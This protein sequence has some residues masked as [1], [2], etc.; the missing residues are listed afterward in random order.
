MKVDNNGNSRLYLVKKNYEVIVKQGDVVDVGTPIFKGNII[1]RV[2]FIDMARILLLSL[3]IGIA[4]MVYF[5]Y[6]RR[7]KLNLL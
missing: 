6:N 3:F 4:V 5:A 7:K 1:N 2:F